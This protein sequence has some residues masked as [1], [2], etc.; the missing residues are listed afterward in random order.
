MDTA[1]FPWPLASPEALMG[2]NEVHVWRACFDVS[3]PQ[4]ENLLA[5]LSADEI[6]RAMRFHFEKDKI[7]FI[8]ARGIL[9]QILGRYL[10]ISP[11][12]FYFG[13]T[14]YGKPFVENSEGY[15]PM[16]FN[17]SHAGDFALFA[18][19][20][21][22]NIGIDIE[23]IRNDVAVMQIAGRF[24]SEQEIRSLE[25]VD[26]SRQIELFFQYWARKEAF[27]KA[28][29]EGVSFPLEKCDVSSVAGSG[30]FPVTLLNNP[31]ENARWHVQDL[32][33][34]NGY[35]AAIVVEEKDCEFSYWDYSG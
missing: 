24:F 25:A 4:C 34:K 5:I 29:G 10:N 17:L 2:S 27:I 20:H 18:F 22:G 7:R 26:G 23:K 33:P 6:E 19:S 3:V 21:S 28:I 11:E 13:Y 8:A 16:F 30:L 12:K 14:S 32:F 31:T 9:R 35:T 15:D 1:I